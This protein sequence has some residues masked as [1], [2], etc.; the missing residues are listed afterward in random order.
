M[1]PSKPG[2]RHPRPTPSRAPNGG[3]PLSAQPPAAGRKTASAPCHPPPP[4]YH[5]EGSHR[6]QRLGCT[7]QPPNYKLWKKTRVGRQAHTYMQAEEAQD[8]RPPTDQPPHHPEP[9]KEGGEGSENTWSEEKESQKRQES[10]ITT[11]KNPRHTHARHITLHPVTPTTKSNGE[12]KR[13]R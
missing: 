11:T 13:N 3:F 9:E 7:R 4:W 5:P 2:P 10:R 8:A 12:R 1:P 6:P